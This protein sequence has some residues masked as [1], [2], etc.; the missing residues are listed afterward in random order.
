MF[1]V[2]TLRID[3]E[4]LKVEGQHARRLG[5]HALAKARKQEMVDKER[6]RDSTT[7]RIALSPYPHLSQQVGEKEVADIISANT[8]IP[9]STI[10]EGERKSLLDMEAYL[11]QRVKGQDAAITAISKVRC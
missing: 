6:V 1:K 7:K 11:R 5:D 4:R 9:C 10:I 3:I 2:N 8:G